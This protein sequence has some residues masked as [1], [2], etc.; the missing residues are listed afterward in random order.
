MKITKGDQV[1]VRSTAGRSVICPVIDATASR[2]WVRLPTQAVVILDWQQREL[3]F[4]GRW[5]GWEFLVD[6]PR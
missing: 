1:S 4:K 2:L 5:A 6:A 3:V